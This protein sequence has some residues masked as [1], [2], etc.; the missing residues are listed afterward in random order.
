MFVCWLLLGAIFVSSITMF[1]V[2]P[3]T[4]NKR[5]QSTEFK[6]STEPKELTTSYEISS[7]D[8]NNT[9]STDLLNNV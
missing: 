7:D 6:E 5:Q 8:L 2:G 1:V 4:E 3:I 9:K